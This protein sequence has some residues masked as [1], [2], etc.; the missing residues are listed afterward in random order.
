MSWT[1]VVAF[2]VI[3]VIFALGDVISLK[4][5]GIVSAMIVAIIIF[6]VFG[7]AMGILPADMIDVSGLGNI[8]GTYGLALVFVN[9][10]S[11]LNTR[12]LINEWKTIVLV[13]FSMVGITIMGFTIGSAIFGRE[14]GLSSIAIICGGLPATL[15]TTEVAKSYGRADIVAFVTTMMS[16]Q[17]LIGIPIASFCLR[18]ESKRFTA[19]PEFL[20][21]AE[22]KKSKFNIKFIPDM[23]K[24]Y[25]CDRAFKHNQLPAHGIHFRAD[26][27]PGEGKSEK[28][29]SGRVGTAWL[30]RG[31][32][33]KFLTV[34][35]PGTLENAGANYWIAPAG[36]GCLLHFRNH[37]G[38][39][40]QM[41]P[42]PFYCC[43]HHLHGG[44]SS[45]LRSDTGS[46]PCGGGRAQSG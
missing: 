22:E 28:S 8:L 20:V 15:V 33:G 5:K 25:Q 19:S 32:S 9:I 10:G 23:P 27:F 3:L 35:V 4:T 18:K 34:P 26:W 41:D 7:G 14:Y 24:Q 29:G 17:N 44:L 6:S 21:K 45:E 43:L 31:S 2:A 12:E 42:L 30:F 13:L 11:S 39:N 16:I 46:N 38:K 37:T 36:S 40:I 1:P